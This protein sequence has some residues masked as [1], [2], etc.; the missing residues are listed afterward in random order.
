MR[1]W[2]LILLAVAVAG[3]GRDAAPAAPAELR[4]DRAHLMPGTIHLVVVNGT[5]EE[6]Q[7]AQVA[8]ADGFADF[9]GPPALA[10]GQEATLAVHYPW[11]AGQSYEVKVLAGGEE[12]IEYEVESD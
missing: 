4:I 9:D 5:D 8:V 2:P 7:L 1:R 6:V 10:P 11:I 12:T 3:C